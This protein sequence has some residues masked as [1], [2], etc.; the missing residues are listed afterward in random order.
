MLAQRSNHRNCQGNY[1]RG[2]QS[3]G[4]PS[5]SFGMIGDSSRY[6]ARMGAA[7][8]F[9]VLAMDLQELLPEAGGAIRTERVFAGVP[10]QEMVGARVRGVCVARGPDFMQQEGSR[11]VGGAMQIVDK[12]S[13][14]LAR[15]PYQGAQ[16][17]F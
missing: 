15:R 7:R 9:E 8:L 6:A 3:A 5:R 11:T 1:R 2:P 13:I 4:F 14:F 17:R 12:A 10:A 16:F